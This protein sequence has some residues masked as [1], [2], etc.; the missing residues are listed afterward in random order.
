MP[1]KYH[2]PPREPIDLVLFVKLSNNNSNSSVQQSD[3]TAK[4]Y[5]AYYLNPSVKAVERSRQLS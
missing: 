2:G 1:R 3:R 5:T 4:V